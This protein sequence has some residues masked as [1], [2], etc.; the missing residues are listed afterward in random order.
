MEVGGDELIV[1]T[2]PCSMGSEMQIMAPSSAPGPTV[3]VIGIE[4]DE[5]GSGQLA[6]EPRGGRAAPVSH[7]SRMASTSPSTV[8][9][10]AWAAT[11]MPRLRAVWVV[12]GPMETALVAAGSGPATLTRFCTVEELVKVM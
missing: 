8:K 2:G 9:T 10:R 1:M 11:W 12:T 4:R 3:A 6:A 7:I 5:G